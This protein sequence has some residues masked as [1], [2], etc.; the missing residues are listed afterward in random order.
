MDSWGGTVLIFSCIPIGNSTPRMH[1][2]VPNS[3]FHRKPW[4]SSVGHRR[5]QHEY[6]EETGREGE[7]RENQKALPVQNCQKLIK[8]IL[9]SRKDDEAGEVAEPLR[10]SCRGP[11]LHS[12]CHVRWLSR[13]CVSSSRGSKPCARPPLWAAMLVDTHKQ[14]HS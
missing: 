4:V 10:V 1:W 14:T 7:E 9:I 13:A 12:Q 5:K 11:E 6:G 8:A 3:R 2:I